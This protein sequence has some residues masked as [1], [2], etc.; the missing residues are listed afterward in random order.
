MRIQPVGLDLRIGNEPC[1]GRV[2]QHHLLN[3]IQAL[4][5]VV[6]QTPIPAGL[7]YRLAR[8]VQAP[9]KLSETARSITLNTG[10]S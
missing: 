6:N 3:L 8:P 1:L 2:S 10:F 7:H 9:K 5:L 4:Q